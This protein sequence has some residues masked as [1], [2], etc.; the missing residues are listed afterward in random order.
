MYRDLLKHIHALALSPDGSRAVVIGSNPRVVDIWDTATGRFLG[1]LPHE[2]QLN[3]LEFAPDG[4]SV[5]SF[6]SGGIGYRWDVDAVIA[7]KK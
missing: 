7:A 6:G 3:R 1:E 4:K 2:F 5:F